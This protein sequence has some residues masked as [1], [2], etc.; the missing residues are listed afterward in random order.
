MLLLEEQ[1]NLRRNMTEVLSALHVLV[2]RSRCEPK[3]D[4]YLLDFYERFQHDP[5]VTQKW[6]RLQST[7]NHPRVVDHGKNDWIF[8]N[9]QVEF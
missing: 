6:L 2:N 7:S 9:T 1:L 4:E 5:L 8:H 3:R